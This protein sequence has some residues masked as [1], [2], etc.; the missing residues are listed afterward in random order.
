VPLLPSRSCKTIGC[1]GIA[2]PDGFCVHCHTIGKARD[3]R[4]SARERGYDE[5]WRVYSKRYLSEHFFCVDPFNRHPLIKLQSEVVDH[6]IP[7]RGNR[8]VFWDKKNHQPLCTS[9]HNFKTAT[10]DGGFGRERK[11]FYS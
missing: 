4:P 11:E 1:G 8:G 3:P 10:Y 5:S 6:I 7:H 9:C 2:E